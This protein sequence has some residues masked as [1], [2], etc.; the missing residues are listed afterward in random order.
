M[1]RTGGYSFEIV[2]ADVGDILRALD[3]DPLAEVLR[4]QREIHEVIFGAGCTPPAVTVDDVMEVVRERD[5]VSP[6]G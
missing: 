4:E 2:R 1:S 5:K 3:R 6:E